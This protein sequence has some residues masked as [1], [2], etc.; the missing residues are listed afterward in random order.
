MGVVMNQLLFTSQEERKRKLKK[1][2][3]EFEDRFKS[4][5]SYPIAVEVF[6]AIPKVI[7]QSIGVES[8]ASFP[9]PDHKSRMFLLKSKDSFEKFRLY[10]RSLNASFE[11]K[12]LPCPRHPYRVLN[13]F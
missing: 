9:I 8:Y 12:L 2:S 6:S 11:A 4:S 5:V 13:G 3:Q 1:D 7:P 10:L